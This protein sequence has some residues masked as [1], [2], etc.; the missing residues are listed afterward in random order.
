LMPKVNSLQTR[1]SLTPNL[2]ASPPCYNCSK[3]LGGGE[4]VPLRAS[5]KFYIPLIEYNSNRG[6]LCTGNSYLLLANTNMFTSGDAG[7][8][9]AVLPKY[10]C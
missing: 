8:V 5:L 7:G 4:L 2:F 9:Y 3:W 1:C 6:H 10:A